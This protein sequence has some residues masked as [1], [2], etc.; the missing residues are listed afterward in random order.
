MLVLP[1]AVV[2]SSVK[3]SVAPQLT[4][5]PTEA[6]NGVVFVPVAPAA[7]LRARAT[8]GHS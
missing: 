2:T 6:V 1:C 5:A 3:W 8:A 7:M 4:P